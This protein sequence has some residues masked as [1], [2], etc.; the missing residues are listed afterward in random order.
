MF[1]RYSM[2]HP[3]KFSLTS[4]L[5]PI[6]HLPMNFRFNAS[7]GIETFAVKARSRYDRKKFPSTQDKETLE[8][9]MLRH[10]NIKRR[11]KRLEDLAHSDLEYTKALDTK[12]C[13]LEVQG[14]LLGKLAIEENHIKGFTMQAD[15][16]IT[17]FEERVKEVEEVIQALQY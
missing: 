9:R 16:Y 5:P 6:S 4:S 3:S 15:F 7:R 14:I 11:R 17:D 8:W 10:R 1:A 2:A 13:M 12:D